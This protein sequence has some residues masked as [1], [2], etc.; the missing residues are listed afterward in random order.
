[1]STQRKGLAYLKVYGDWLIR[2]E[3][4]KDA[5]FGRF[6]RA[7]IDYVCNGKEPTIDGNE[8]YLFDFVRPTLDHD[9]E[10]YREK[11]EKNT[12][13]G[14][15]GAAA[16]W[17]NNSERHAENG[18]RYI[19]NDD[20][21][22]EEDKREMRNEE[23]LRYMS[24]EKRGVYRGERGLLDS[25][26]NPQAQQFSDKQREDYQEAW[27]SFNAMRESIGKPVTEIDHK[28]IATR[29]KQFGGDD[30][31]KHTKMLLIATKNKTLNVN[32]LKEDDQPEQKKSAV[33]SMVSNIA[34]G[35]SM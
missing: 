26:R 31:V 34:S 10:K 28:G 1:M 25:N 4:L 18:E 29:L 11:V 13:N 2:F 15:K 22:Q 5:E 17:G 12:E 14:H 19:E 8:G 16:R 30:I 23:E 20:N 33:G 6:I 9:A 3:K 35:F 27:R 24:E 7:C 21:S 32:P